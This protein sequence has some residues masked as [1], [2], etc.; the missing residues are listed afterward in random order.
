MPSD[1]RTEIYMSQTFTKESFNAFGISLPY[2]FHEPEN[3]A[4]SGK[5][6][7]VLFLHGAGERGDDNEAQLRWGV[8]DALADPES[9]LHGAYIIAPQCPLEKQWVDTPWAEG[10]YCISKVKETPYLAAAVQLVKETMEKYSIDEDLVAV[11]G[12]S[13]GGFGSWDALSRYPEI[14]KGGF[15]CCGSGSPEAAP[16]LLNKPI[17]TYH[18]DVD[19]T[20][21]VS[22]TRDVVNAVKAAGGTDITYR[23]YA[24][25][26][27][28]T[29]Q[30]AYAEFDDMKALF[31]ALQ[32]KKDEKNI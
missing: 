3:M 32:K 14:F 27:H 12:I 15:I 23:E 26:G 1:G 4:D 25:M 6:P 18:G 8:L 29:W 31:A 16:L 13:M 30:R 10:A 9:P 5:Y 7:L 24:D 20:V 11:M 2:R 22:G 19:D 17:F 21:P 28:W